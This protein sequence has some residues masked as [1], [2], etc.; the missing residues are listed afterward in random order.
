[1]NSECVL[2]GRFSCLF[3]SRTSDSSRVDIA[4]LANNPFGFAVAP[5]IKTKSKEF[6]CRSFWR[7]DK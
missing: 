5:V 4:N 2:I 6:I 3:E 1:M 7:T